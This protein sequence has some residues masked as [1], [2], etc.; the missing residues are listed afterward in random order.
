MQ[1]H[2]GVAVTRTSKDQPAPVPGEPESPGGRAAE[3]LREFE[4]ARVLG[5]DETPP[6]DHGREHEGHDESTV[7][8]H[9]RDTSTTPGADGTAPPPLDDEV[10]PSDHDRHPVPPRGAAP[11]D[12]N[13][14]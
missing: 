8:E 4:Q 13:S 3:R 9:D 2:G 14:D 6:N 12:H 5:D 7:A 11:D 1:G 10:L